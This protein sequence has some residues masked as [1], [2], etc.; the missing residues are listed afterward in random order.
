MAFNLFPF[1]NLHNLNTDWILKTIK[2]LKAAAETAASQVQ[3]ALANAVLYTS[4]SKETSERRVACT[5]IHAVSYDSTPLSSGDAAH[6]RS[7]IGAAAAGDVPDVTDVL[8][9]SSQS[10]TIDQKTQA[11]TNIGAAAAGDVADVLRYSSQSL[12]STQKA[13]ARTNI[14]AVGQS[15][16]NFYQGFSIVEGDSPSNPSV[17]IISEHT[18]TV[19]E[20]TLEGSLGDRKVVI[21]GVADPTAI[22]QAANK[23][24]VDTAIAAAVVAPEGVVKYN[25]AQTLTNPQKTQARSNIGAADASTVSNLQNLAAY[26]L[27][28]TETAT[29]TFSITGGTLAGA[30]EA[31]DHG[32]PVIIDLITLL[33]GLI[34]GLA[35]FSSDSSGNIV[36]ILAKPAAPGVS[37]SY[38]FSI[39]ITNDGTDDILTCTPFEFK[40]MPSSGILDAGK[41]LTVS[42]MGAPGWEQIKPV[43]VLETVSAT[44]TIASAQDNHIY[45]FTRDLTSLSLTTGSGTYMICFHSGSTATTTSFPVSILGLDDFVP[46]VNTYYEISIM[47]GR[48]VWMGWPDPVEEL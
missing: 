11:R 39:L 6:A 23:G 13:Q 44:P 38:G 17:D 46:A 36:T 27:Q 43:T 42:G 3:E 30:Q 37:S 25:E 10:L 33:D 32:A 22:N 1:T 8:R 4:Q 28:I 34:R 16:P 2:E 31:Q 45:K 9:Y 26:T 48:A 29:D 21:N 12:N 20:L 14:G 15:S 47:D 18:G 5:N 24:Y 41:S 7:N 40:L 19:N 35:S